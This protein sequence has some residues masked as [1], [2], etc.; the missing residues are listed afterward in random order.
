MLKI[1]GL[2]VHQRERRTD[3]QTIGKYKVN[4]EWTF[5]VAL[6]LFT[7]G[8]PLS[9][10]VGRVSLLFAVAA[11]DVPHV[12]VPIEKFT[13]HLPSRACGRQPKRS[14]AP[15]HHVLL[16]LGPPA[17][18]TNRTPDVLL[19]KVWPPTC[20]NTSPELMKPQPACGRQPK[21]S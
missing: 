11:A 3:Q 4:S 18:A 19:T 6:V 7:C 5:P 9:F 10:R 12:A 13:F 2:F 14:R 17:A 20:R 16:S 1:K 15:H 21:R 8:A